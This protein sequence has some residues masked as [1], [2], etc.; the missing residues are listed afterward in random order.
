MIYN[1][2]LGPHFLGGSKYFTELLGK[3]RDDRRKE[4]KMKKTSF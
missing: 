1:I 2:V 4:Q 3:M